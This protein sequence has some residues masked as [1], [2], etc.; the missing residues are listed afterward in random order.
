MKLAIAGLFLVCAA[1]A[2]A[3]KL[4]V[5]IVDRQ[6]HDNRYTY[7]VPGHS[8]SISNTNVN[9]DGGVNYANYNGTST[10][11]T[12]SIPAQHGSSSVRGLTLSLLPPDGRIAVVNCDIKFAEHIAGAAGNTGIAA[13]PGGITFKLISMAAKPN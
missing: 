1:S 4:D 3:Q 7:F 8:Y 12:V 13:N 2:S 11:P 9:C 5:K 6:E 10:T